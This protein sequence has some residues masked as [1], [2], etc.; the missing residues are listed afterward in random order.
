MATRDANRR[1][2][3]W[4][5]SRD[6]PS[7]ADRAEVG[8]GQTGWK[9]QSG[10]V[11]RFARRGPLGVAAIVVLLLML[12]I[13]VAGPWTFTGDPE[14]IDAL[15][16]F[17]H[18]TRHYPMGTDYLG[19][20]VLARIAV[21]LRV[22]I[23]LAAV[24]AL[25]AAF[26]GA[27]LG[28]IAGYYGRAIDDVIIRIADVFFGF[29]I[30]LLALLVE[31]VTQPGL[32]G[33][34]VTIV[35]ATVPIFI[36]VA[37][38]PTLSVRSAEYVIAARVMGASSRRLILKHILPNV[39]TPLLVQLTF[40]LSF[41]L[42]AEGALSFL[43]LGVQPPRPSLGSLL[44]DGQTY[45]QIAPWMMLFPGLTLAFAI[46]AINLLGDELQTFTDPRLRSR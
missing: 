16:T 2:P 8:R 38:G 33:V 20:S 6:R 19:R 41:A 25:F 15:A 18:P 21:G 11:R 43:G 45:M 1:Q 14:K 37:R 34:V 29:P 22:S 26:V 7:A 40:T 4:L 31:M 42:I 13:A 39:L 5:P 28:L 27:L 30:L 24:S 32:N 17:G 12:L 44:R 46:L 9:R 23:A 36:R 10:T 3:G 35:I